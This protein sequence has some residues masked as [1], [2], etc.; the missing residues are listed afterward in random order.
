ME[1]AVSVT[2]PNWHWIYEWS[3]PATIHAH[4]VKRV[5]SF[6][7]TKY[8]TYLVVE[9]EDLGKALVI[10]GKTQS[11][12]VDEFVYHESLV[13]PAM[14]AH[15]SPRSVLILGGGEGATAREAL[16]FPTVERVVMVDIDEEIVNACKELLPEWHK[17]AFEDPR[18][19]LVIDDAEHYLNTTSEKFDVIIGDLVDPEAGGPAW[20]L[21]TKETYQLVRS[22]LNPGGVFVTQATSPTLTPKVHA[23]IYNTVKA[24][25][26][27]AITYYVYM[28][29]FEGLWGFVMGSGDLNLEGLKE[30][31]VDRALASIGVK[32]NR[33]YDGESHRNMF[34]V[35]KFVRDALAAERAVSTLQ[36]PVY[37]P[38]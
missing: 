7:K 2:Y 10:D 36:N 17:G 12:M 9:F 37:V 21:Y 16:K 19:K 20:R 26:G 14:V 38:A 15:G 29:G 28:R 34:N 31:D 30:L 11:A 1:R 33:F 27:H 4:A 23:T 6:G 18:L 32:G 22:R 13:Q 5:Y 24:A 25:F 35:P 3:T 8:Q